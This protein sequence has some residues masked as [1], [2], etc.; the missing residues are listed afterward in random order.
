MLIFDVVSKTFNPSKTSFVSI[1]SVML[2]YTKNIVLIKVGFFTFSI[3]MTNLVLI[4][5]F[6]KGKVSALSLKLVWTRW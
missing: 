1:I 3:W 2:E 6:E 5:I 4:I